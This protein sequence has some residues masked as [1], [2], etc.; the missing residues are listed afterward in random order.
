MDWIAKIV[1]ETDLADTHE[2]LVEESRRTKGSTGWLFPC[3]DWALLFREYIQDDL[4][5]AGMSIAD[6]LRFYDPETPSIDKFK[7]VHPFWERMKH[8]GYAQAFSHTLRKL[9]GIELTLPL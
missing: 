5:C 7:L 8:T 6:E 3:D 2:H 1:A 9:Y 4:H